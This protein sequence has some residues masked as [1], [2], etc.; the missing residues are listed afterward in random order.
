RKLDPSQSVLTGDPV[1]IASAAGNDP[2]TGFSVSADGTVAYRSGSSA[3]RFLTL[4]DHAGKVV[5][6]LEDMNGPE[7]S[8]NETRVAFDRT[9]KANRDVW[10]F[11]LV[12][13]GSVRFTT[14]S[15]V[16]GYPVWSPDGTQIAFE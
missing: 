5:E 7:L 14:H 15:K 6:R 16:D 8:S 4:F 11:D 2:I 1:T 10:L 3:P 9:M 12:R 13:R